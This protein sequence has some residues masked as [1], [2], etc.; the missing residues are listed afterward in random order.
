MGAGDRL[1]S[2]VA[3]SMLS[4]LSLILMARPV[5]IIEPLDVINILGS[6]VA[7]DLGDGRL[8]IGGRHIS[9]QT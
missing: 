5:H 9:R 2:I 1:C 7:K 4:K 6:T 3:A 8:V